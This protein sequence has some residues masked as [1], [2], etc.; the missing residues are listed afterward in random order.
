M[1]KTGFVVSDLH[2]GSYYGLCPPIV[3]LPKGGI[4]RPNPGQKYLYQ[5]WKKILGRLPDKLDFLIFNGDLIDGGQWKDGGRG[6]IITSTKYQRDACKQVVQPLLDR[7]KKIYVTRGTRYHEDKDDMEEFAED[8]G[9]V[10]GKDGIRCRPV[11]RVRA[12]DVFLEA[13]HKISGAW[14]YTLSA[15]QREHRADKE[16][17]ERKGYSADCLV[18]A[19]RH[20]YN[21]GGGWGWHVIT[22]PCMELQSDWAEE[23]QPN[24]WI[25]DLGGVVVTL[26]PRNKKYNRQCVFWEPIIYPHPMPEV[27]CL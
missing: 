15:L 20:Q 8:I 16:A 25:P 10:A 21:Y 11:V 5:V 24:L 13:R 14:L 22:L 3:E 12:S 7:A 18:G 17:A 27:F 26:E 23:K 6:L 2:V 4:Y 9:A 1:S 19:H